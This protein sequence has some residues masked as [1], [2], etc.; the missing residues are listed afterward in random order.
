MAEGVFRSLTS[1]A[2]YKSLIRHVDSCGTG[3]YH[4]GDDPD[5]RTMS[6][7]EDHGICDYNHAARK[8]YSPYIPLRMVRSRA[9]NPA[10]TNSRQ[11]QLMD[12]EEFDYVFAMDRS[13]LRDLQRLQQ[14]KPNSKAK[15]MLF[16]EFSGGK[17]EQIDDPYY[18]ARNGFEIAYEQSVRF[19]KNFLKDTFPDV[20]A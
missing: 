12:F 18:G 5:S 3:A 11:V 14:R 6:T 8:V 19:T 10:R 1:K 17:A 16:G 2:P 20:K 15:V 9:V 7:L 13:N 4:T